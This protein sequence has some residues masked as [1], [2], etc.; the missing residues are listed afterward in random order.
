MLLLHQCTALGK[1]RSGLAS[2][3]AACRELAPPSQPL[4]A[5]GEVVLGGG[6]AVRDG[7]LKE[8]AC[9]WGVVRH[10]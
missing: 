4:T 5:A 8:P 1:Q 6:A 3:A 10:G 7:N 2:S 9:N